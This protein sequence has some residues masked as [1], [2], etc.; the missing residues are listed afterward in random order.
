MSKLLRGRTGIV[1]AHRLGTIKRADEILVLENGRIL[2]YGSREALASDAAS[3]F[4]SLLQAGL[5]E[6]TA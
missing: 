4:A 2:E 6:V 3:R 1:I 5:E